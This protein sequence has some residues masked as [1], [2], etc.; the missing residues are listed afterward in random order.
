M[1]NLYDLYNLFNNF[2]LLRIYIIFIYKYIYTGK[3]N[4]L[5]RVQINILIYIQIIL[6]N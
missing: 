2:I 1:I 3:I 5:Q 6:I 4:L